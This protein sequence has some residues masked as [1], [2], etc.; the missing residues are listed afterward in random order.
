VEEDFGINST[1]VSDN[2]SKISVEGAK[3]W[4]EVKALGMLGLLDNER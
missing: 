4:L 2:L 3:N 1:S